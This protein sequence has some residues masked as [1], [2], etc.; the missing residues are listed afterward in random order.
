VLQFFETLMVDRPYFAGA[1]FT[2]AD[3]V[4]GTLVPSVAM[5]GIPIDAYPKLNTWLER[6]SQR[7]SFQQT[8]PTPEQIQAALPNIRKI[9]EMRQ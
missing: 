4:A 9:L 6:L 2:M 7:D 3:I 8:A 1:T 5:F